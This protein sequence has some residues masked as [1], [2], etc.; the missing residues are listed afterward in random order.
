MGTPRQKNAANEKS[1]FRFQSHEHALSFL[2]E[3][4][5]GEEQIRALVASAEA[6]I[7]MARVMDTFKRWVHE[8]KSPPAPKQRYQLDSIAE[9]VRAVPEKYS[10]ALTEPLTFFSKAVELVHAADKLHEMVNSAEAQLREL[11][12][13][14]REL[15]D[16]NPLEG[17]ER[18]W[19]EELQMLVASM[20][21][22][23]GSRNLKL[24]YRQMEAVMVL[25]GYRLPGEDLPEVVPDKPREEARSTRREQLRR[26][27]AA[28]PEQFASSLSTIAVEV[29]ADASVDRQIEAF[30]AREERD[31]EERRQ[32]SLR[33]VLTT[34]RRREEAWRKLKSKVDEKE[35]VKN[36]NALRVPDLATTPKTGS[37]ERSCEPGADRSAGAE[38]CAH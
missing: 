32:T 35:L 23:A 2:R 18:W 14:A 13:Q 29:A 15:L 38:D 8:S 28:K 24:T 6:G 22:V 33:P 12:R 34:L 1:A 7:A 21:T 5:Y 4:G 36:L 10:E 27:R 31:E 17:D 20:L 11:E 3:Q 16:S 37:T 19:D 30:I 9:F 25:V 26:W